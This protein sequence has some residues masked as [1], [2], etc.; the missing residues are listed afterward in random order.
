MASKTAK[1][2]P[3][4][5]QD[6]Q[7]CTQDGLRWPRDGARRPKKPPTGFRDGPKRRPGGLP[8]GHEEAKIIDCP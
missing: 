4:C 5:L 8:G 7:R 6:D 1:M 3:R 2:A